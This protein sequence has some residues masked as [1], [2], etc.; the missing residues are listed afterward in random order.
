MEATR[1]R[2]SYEAPV[3]NSCQ[4]VNMYLYNIYPYINVI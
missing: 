4:P 2:E 1:Q 3:D